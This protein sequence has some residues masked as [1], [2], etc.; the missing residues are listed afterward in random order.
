[1]AQEN[2]N[3]EWP[4]AVVATIG[5]I[6]VIGSAYLLKEPQLLWGFVGVIWLTSFFD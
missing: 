6:A 2:K 1:M 3:S 5:T 4:K